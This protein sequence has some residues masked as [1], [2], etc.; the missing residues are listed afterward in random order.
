MMGPS[1]LV[2]PVFAGQ[3]SRKVVLPRGNWYDFYTGKPAGNGQTITVRTKLDEIPLFVKDGGI[4]PMMP[5]VNNIANARGKVEL[6]VRH[7]GKKENTYLLYDDDGE[8]FDYEK[9][10][11]SIT[12]LKAQRRNGRLTGTASTSGNQWQSRY[13]DVSWKFMSQ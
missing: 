5:A 6:E 11:H 12:E 3:K 4:V 7:Y 2:A 1:I 10:I 13:G 8:T 9:G